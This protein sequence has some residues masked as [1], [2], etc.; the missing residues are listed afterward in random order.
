MASGCTLP[1]LRAMTKKSE[2]GAAQKNRLG[3]LNYLNSPKQ[4]RKAPGR[5]LYER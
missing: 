2:T 3:R 4:R 1:K 5:G